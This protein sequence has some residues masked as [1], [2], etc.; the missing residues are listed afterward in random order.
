MAAFT[1]LDW[2]RIDVRAIVTDGGL[3]T[4]DERRHAACRDWLLRQGYAIDTF[5]CRPGL[6]VAIPA[7]GRLL[8]WEEEFGYPLHSHGRSLDALRDGFEFTIPEG[9]GRVFE[10]LRPDLAWQEDHQW[11]CGLLSITQEQC[12]QQLALGRRFFALLVVPEGSPF[13]GAVV[14]EITVPAPF[15]DPHPDRHEFAA[16]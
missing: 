16:G 4:I 13:I 15:W 7:L 1:E 2:G 5:D 6:A 9:G 14:E 11:L 3:A 10:I 12:R 8:R